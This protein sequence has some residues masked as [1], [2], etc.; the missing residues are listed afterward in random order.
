MSIVT[1]VEPHNPALRK[2]DRIPI[3]PVVSMLMLVYSIRY[4]F[5]I[6]H[7]PSHSFSSWKANSQVSGRENGEISP[8]HLLGDHGIRLPASVASMM[9][10]ISIS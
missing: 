6:R 9:L 4:P 3:Q 8:D 7:T 5:V 1:G 10:R 2:I